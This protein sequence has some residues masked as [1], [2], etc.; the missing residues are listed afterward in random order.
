MSKTIGIFGGAF[1][2]VHVGHTRLISEIQKT[3]D[4]EKIFIIPSGKPVFKEIHFV[5]GD[6]RIEM[7]DISFKKN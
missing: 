6:K 4:F 7:L 5:D 1:D 3:I 2:P